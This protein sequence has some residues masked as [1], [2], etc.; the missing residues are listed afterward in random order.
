MQKSLIP[1]EDQGVPL[2]A[3]A[4]SPDHTKRPTVILCHAWS[5]RDVFIE[6]K[7][8]LISQMGYVAFAL[9]M[10]GKGV[11]GK[12]REENIALK[13]PFIEDRALL[14]R[15]VLEGLK[16]QRNCPPSIQ[17]VSPS[18]VLGLAAYVRLTLRVVGRT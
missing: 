2:E 12:S 9:D 17:T 13:T 4:I 1:Y 5:G 7:T 11:L 14:Q 8:A 6:E 10:Y 15:R 3:L 16:R 18:S